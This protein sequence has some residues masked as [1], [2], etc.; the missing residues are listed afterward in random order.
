MP[1]L[2]LAWEKYFNDN[3]G[4]RKLLIGSYRMAALYVLGTSPNPAVVVSYDFWQSR[5]ASDPAIVGKTL[6]LNGNTLT[7]IGVATIYSVS[8]DFRANQ[9][10]ARFWSQ[11]YALPIAFAAMV[12]W[13]CWSRCRVVRRGR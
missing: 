6:N 12:A 13:N 7:V 8:W 3:F 1:A 11:V 10:G 4:L 5:F 9:P 2:A